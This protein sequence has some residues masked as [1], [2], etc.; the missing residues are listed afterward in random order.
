MAIAWQREIDT[1]RIGAGL[2]IAI[3]V[4][5]NIA[6]AQDKVV[7]L[8]NGKDLNGWYVYTT[9][10]QQENPG[11]FQVIDGMIYVSGGHDDVAY[12]GGLITKREFENY[13]LRWEYKWGVATYGIRKGKAR[14]SGVLVHCVGPDGPSPWPMSY[15]YQVEEGATGDLWMVNLNPPVNSEEKKSII[16][17]TESEVRDEQ[18]YFKPSGTPFTFKD[19]GHQNWFDRDPA[20]KDEIGFRGRR[21]L[22]SPRGEWTRCELVARGKNLEFY[23]NGVLA[24][25]ATELNVVR[26]KILL[27]TEGAE[28]WYRNIELQPLASDQ[29]R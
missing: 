18:R 25:R 1:T 28:V 9:E 29:S 16:C 5:V 23:V 20:W 26:G 17:E 12:L 15:E 4:V 27:Q 13:R 7:S 21:D 8:F 24:N 19:T 10:T 11:V 6:Q 2:L 3:V 22:E 14:D